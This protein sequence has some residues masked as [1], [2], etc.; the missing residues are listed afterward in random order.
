MGSLRLEDRAWVA[1]VAVVGGTRK[2]NVEVL[3]TEP[4]LIKNIKIV[5]APK[6]TSMI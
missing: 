2:N 6:D 3:L 1:G 4:A 5:K